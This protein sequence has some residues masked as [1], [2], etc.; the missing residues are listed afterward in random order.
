MYNYQAYRRQ[1]HL[2][3]RC[4]QMRRKEKR[5]QLSRERKP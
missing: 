3:T 2:N 5:A 1:A 4:Q